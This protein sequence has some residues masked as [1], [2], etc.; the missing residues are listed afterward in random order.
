MTGRD[1]GITERFQLV[2]RCHFKLSQID[3]P[4]IQL[5]VYCLMISDLFQH[6]S[7]RLQWER[8]RAEGRSEGNKTKDNG[9][10]GG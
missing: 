4:S 6:S 8:G 5:T 1:N 9:R 10:G 2:K 7:R 3:H